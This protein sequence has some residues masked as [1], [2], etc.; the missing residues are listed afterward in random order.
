MRSARVCRSGCQVR[1]G[2][3]VERF[4]GSHPGRAREPDGRLV[5]LVAVLEEGERPALVA[6]QV[7]EAAELDRRTHRALPGREDVDVGICPAEAD[8]HTLAS[9]RQR[10]PRVPLEALPK[11][12]T[13]V[14]GNRTSPGAHGSVT[15]LYAARCSALSENE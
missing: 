12:V 13:S 3:A 4:L 11:R 9:P 10:S 15:A 6:P 14:L 8:A 1:E 7:A 2:G 5:G